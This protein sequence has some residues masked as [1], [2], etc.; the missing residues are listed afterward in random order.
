MLVALQRLVNALGPECPACYP[1]L[2]PVLRLCTDPTQVGVAPALLISHVCHVW[3]LPA[4]LLGQPAARSAPA[5]SAV[6]D[7]LRPSSD[8]ARVT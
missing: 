5:G 4:V 1:L 8:P 2:M 7:P 3:V 6:W